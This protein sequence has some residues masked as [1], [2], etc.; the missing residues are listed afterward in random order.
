MKVLLV[1][2]ALVLTSGVGPFSSSSIADDTPVSARKP[3]SKQTLASQRGGTDF[4]TLVNLNDV[5]GSVDHNVA[6]NV[7]TGNNSISASF[8]GAMGLPIVIQ[9]SGNNVLIQNATIVNVQI[10]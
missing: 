7:V 5:R 8:A 10:Q 6:S 9:N 3:V 4:K 1:G 2:S